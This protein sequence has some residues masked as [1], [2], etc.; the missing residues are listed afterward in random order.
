MVKWTSKW[1]PESGLPVL[2]RV[3]VVGNQQLADPC[4][5][6]LDA[7]GYESSTAYRGLT[8]FLMAEKQR[9]EV[10]LIDLALPDMDGIDL[11]NAIR[12][13]EEMNEMLLI[14]L[15]DG[16]NDLLTYQASLLVAFNRYL[17]KPINLPQLAR[18]IQ[19][20]WRLT[21]HWPSK[22]VRRS[23]RLG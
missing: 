3:L 6:A 17:A 5:N 1:R 2:P 20:M 22:D 21:R 7:A 18:F 4:H 16:E 10:I 9:P 19:T 13:N 11:A 8:G 15:Y 23:R 14:A 12:S